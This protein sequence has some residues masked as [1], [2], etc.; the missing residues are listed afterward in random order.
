MAPCSAL[1]QAQ[2]LVLFEWDNMG[3]DGRQWDFIVKYGKI[4]QLTP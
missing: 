3:L 2:P 1:L 4:R